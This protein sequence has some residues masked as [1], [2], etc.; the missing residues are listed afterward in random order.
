MRTDARPMLR[1]KGRGNLLFGGPARALK[2]SNGRSGAMVFPYTPTITYQRGANY[3]LYDLP[4]TNYQPLYYQSTS[5]PSVQ[6]TGL[7]T[8]Q[9]EDELRYTQGVLHLSLIHI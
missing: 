3:G 6:V 2:S 8:N 4:H 7:F 5:S 9:T 1:P